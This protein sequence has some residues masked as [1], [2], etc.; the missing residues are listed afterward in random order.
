MRVMSV[1]I[2]QLCAGKSRGERTGD[3]GNY[4]LLSSRRTF[5][6]YG[7]GGFAFYGAETPVNRPV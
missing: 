3:D 5:E 4:K 7:R 2:M 6:V 1:R